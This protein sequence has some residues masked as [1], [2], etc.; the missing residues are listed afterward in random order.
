MSPRAAAWLAW[1][2]CVATLVILA[3]SLL[4]ILLGW[5]TWRE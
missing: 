2:L 1:S 3:L 4:L 5:Q